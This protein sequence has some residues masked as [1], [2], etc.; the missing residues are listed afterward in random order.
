MALTF[1]SA[2]ADARQRLADWS[3][4][5]Q[6]WTQ[7]SFDIAQKQEVKKQRDRITEEQHIAE[8]L[9]PAQQL[10]RALLIVVPRAT[11]VALVEGS[12]N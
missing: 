7:L 6:D 11:P 3:G 5:A 10:V 9:A 1:Q 4:R 2:E 12:T 8:S